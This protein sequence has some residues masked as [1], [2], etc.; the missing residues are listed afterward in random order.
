[1]R[2]SLHG[3]DFIAIVSYGKRKAAIDSPSVR[4]HGAGAALAVIAALLGAGQGE[5]LAQQVE[6]RDPGVDL[7]T[8]RLAVDMQ[9][10]RNGIRRRG[11]GWSGGQ[12]NRSGGHSDRCDAFA[13]GYPEEI[14]SHGFPRRKKQHLS[15]HTDC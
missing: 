8:V 1:V 14:V 2:E 3:G 6:Q 4:Q 9:L 13:A 10:N 7:Q 5:I 11:G 15:G 12:R